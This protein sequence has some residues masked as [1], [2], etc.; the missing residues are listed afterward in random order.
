MTWHDSME[1]PALL[2]ECLLHRQLL[3]LLVKVLQLDPVSLLGTV[4]LLVEAFELRFAALIKV[5]AF[6][7]SPAK[8]S[9]LSHHFQGISNALAYKE[10]IKSILNVL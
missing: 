10:F 6:D 2:P 9:P 1:F 3:A 8:F 5:T 4:T 7:S